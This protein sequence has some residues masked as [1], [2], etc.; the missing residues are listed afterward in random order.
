[1]NDL[2][3]QADSCKKEKQELVEYLL[4]E[5]HDLHIPVL[6]QVQNCKW[7][8]QV[9]ITCTLFFLVHDNG[10]GN[11]ASYIVVTSSK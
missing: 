6:T 3:L 1:M 10:F 7:I 11:V 4:L 5:K 2:K 9:L 8:L